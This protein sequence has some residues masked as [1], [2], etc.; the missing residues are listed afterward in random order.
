VQHLTDLTLRLARECPNLEFRASRG[1]LT[2]RRGGLSVRLR[3]KSISNFAARERRERR[4]EGVSYLDLGTG[5]LFVDEPG[6]YLYITLPRSPAVRLTPFHCALLG[7]ILAREGTEWLVRGLVGSQVDLI[8]RMK[9]ELGVDLSPMAMSRLLDVL[10]R[11][12]I[13]G[14][15]VPPTWNAERACDALRSDFRLSAV[16]QAETY[17]G[18]AEEVEVNLSES[19]GVGF[20]R[21]VAEALNRASG[22]WIEPRDYL[23]E[24]SAITV[25]RELL[26]NPVPREYR[27]ATVTIRPVARLSLSLLT[28]GTDSIQPALAFVEAMQSTSPVQRQVGVEAWE[29]WTRERM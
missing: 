6:L 14:E 7:L 11:K 3:R 13:V 27:G 26:G 24:R 17:A 9:F 4:E 2:I 23:I 28:A 5:S 19:L 29:K 22:A 10:R 18:E 16:G 15:G 8:R 25:V 21:G 12:G 20:A 1:G